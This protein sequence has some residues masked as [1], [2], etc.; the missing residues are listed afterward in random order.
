[1]KKEALKRFDPQSPEYVFLH[2]HYK[3]GRGKR[4]SLSYKG[5]KNPRKAFL[6]AIVDLR[7]NHNAM[8][9]DMVIHV[10]MQNDLSFWIKVHKPSLGPYTDENPCVCVDCGK[11]REEWLFPAAPCYG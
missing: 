11:P 10:G 8:L 3:K 9:A 6:L 2:A 4:P 1:L 5:E 7:E